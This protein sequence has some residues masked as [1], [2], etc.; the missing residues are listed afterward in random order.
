M[1]KRSI[2][3]LPILLILLIW[4]AFLKF[5]ISSDKDLIDIYWSDLGINQWQSESKLG[6]DFSKF[7]EHK[8]ETIIVPEKKGQILIPMPSDALLPKTEKE[9]QDLSSKIYNTLKSKINSGLASGIKRFEIRTEQNI[10]TIGYFSSDRQRKVEKFIQAFCL[11]LNRLKNELSSKYN[12]NIYGIWGSNGGFMASKVVPRFKSGFINGGILIDARAWK[13]D[14][15]K[16][17]YAL[18]KNLAI[19]NT[20]GDAPARPGMIAYHDTAKMLKK[21]L[22]GL[23]LYWVDCKGPDIFIKKHLNSMHWGTPLLVKEFK[24]NGYTKSWKT[25]GSNLRNYIIANFKTRRIKKLKKSSLYPSTILKHKKNNIYPDTPPPPP[26][27]PPPPSPSISGV[28]IAPSLSKAGKINT[29]I[30]E[31]I[32]K[33]RPSNDAISWPIELPEEELDSW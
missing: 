3:A 18:N 17:Y 13:N 23:K 32:L 27:P 16:L 29:E 26:P 12:V 19:I 20:A 21:E 25:T 1:S 31:K 22:P 30:K 28:Y 14:V 9:W 8:K 15:K 2:Y 7:N 10:N 24:G 4:G 33:S 5:A 6:D 11:A